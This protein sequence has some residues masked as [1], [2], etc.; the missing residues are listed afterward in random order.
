MPL[1]LFLALNNIRK[2]SRRHF[3]DF[4]LKMDRS[5]LAL[6]DIICQPSACRIIIK[7]IDQS[8]DMFYRYQYSLQVLLKRQK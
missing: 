3:V 2:Q 1:V 5:L 7:D 4:P 6:I 8:F